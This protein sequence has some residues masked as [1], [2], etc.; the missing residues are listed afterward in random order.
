MWMLRAAALLLL[1]CLGPPAPGREVAG[2]PV[3]EAL[4]LEGRTLQLNGAGLRTRLFVQVY[5]GALYLERRSSDAPALLA[6]DAPW[7]VVLVFRREVGHQKV[8]D[9][10]V[11]AF[12]QNSPGQLDRLTPQLEV[13]HAILQDLKEGH[14]I[15]LHYLPGAGTTL[16]VPGGATATVP[17]RLFGEAVL[18]TWLGDRPSDPGLK[19]ALLGR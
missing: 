3:P 4:Q 11:A 14:A 9:G 16:T 18:R 15:R 17:G 2:V 19:D 10:F 5:V 8:L 1:V 7:A 6:A 13:F 12:E